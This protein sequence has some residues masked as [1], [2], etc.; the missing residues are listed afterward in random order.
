VGDEIRTIIIEKHG[1]VTFIVTTTKNTLHPENESRLLS[2]E[3]DDTRDQTKKVLNK[4][5]LVEGLH[6]AESVDNKSWQ[7]FQRWLAVGECR[8]V[9]PFALAIAELIEPEAV[10]LRRDFGQV[11]RAIKA[12]ALLHRG[13]RQHDA[14]GQIIAD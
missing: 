1:P 2:L 10:R 3:I 8:V 6:G 9:V 11:L 14:A 7:D 5:A 12:H 4:V 13:Q